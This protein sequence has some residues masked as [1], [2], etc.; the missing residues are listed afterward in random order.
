VPRG[1]EIDY[2]QPR[3]P[4]SCWTVFKYSAIVGTAMP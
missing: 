2:A 3:V 1:A 4:Q